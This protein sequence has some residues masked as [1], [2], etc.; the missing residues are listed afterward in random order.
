MPW[1]FVFLFAYCSE[2]EHSLAGNGGSVSVTCRLH[3]N[4]SP[5]F[6]PTCQFQ[7]HDSLVSEHF[8]VVIFPTSTY[9]E[10]LI[11]YIGE[12][13]DLSMYDTHLLKR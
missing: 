5:I 3:A 10:Q 13:I 7:R 2:A 1:A 6:A 8:C 12:Y 11:L 4:M 9:Q